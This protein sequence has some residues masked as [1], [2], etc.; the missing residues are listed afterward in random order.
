MQITKSYFFSKM[1]KIPQ[2]G[3]NAI[4][5][6]REKG[7][8]TLFNLVQNLGHYLYS[9]IAVSPTEVPIKEKKPAPKDLHFSVLL[10]SF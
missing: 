9:S 1:S 7:Y 2:V 5:F 6:P 4:K 10:L 3:G 8:I